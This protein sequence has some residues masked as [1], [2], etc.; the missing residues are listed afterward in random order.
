MTLIIAIIIA[1]IIF[2]AVMWIGDVWVSG[3]EVLDEHPD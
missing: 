3:A 2:R 1:F